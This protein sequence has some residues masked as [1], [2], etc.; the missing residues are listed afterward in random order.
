MDS[1]NSQITVPSTSNSSTQR[2]VLVRS[3]VLLPV[4]QPCLG[5]GCVV[6]NSVSRFHGASWV[7]GVGV[8]YSAVAQCFLPVSAKL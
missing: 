4:I 2:C 7:M 8:G 1:Q 3:F 6:A 5:G